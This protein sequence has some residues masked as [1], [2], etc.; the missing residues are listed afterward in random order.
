M[1][2]ITGPKCPIIICDN[3]EILI[4]SYLLLSREV[5]TI[6]TEEITL[7]AV[8]IMAVTLVVIIVIAI[9]N[10]MWKRHARQE[11]QRRA[12]EEQ[13]RDDDSHRL[14]KWN[15]EVYKRWLN[16]FVVRTDD[17][18]EDGVSEFHV[19]DPPDE[20]SPAEGLVLTDI[21]EFEDAKE[22]LDGWR[23]NVSDL[24]AGAEAL[25]DKTD[26]A[27]RQHRAAVS[28]V[29]GQ[30][31][32]TFF[33][34]FTAQNSRHPP[35]ANHYNLNVTIETV[36]QRSYSWTYEVKEPTFD[37][38][39]DQ[40]E[41][42]DGMVVR[43]LRNASVHVAGDSENVPDMD[44]YEKVLIRCSK[45]HDASDAARTYIDCRGKRKEALKKFKNAL[46]KVTVDID[47]R[48]V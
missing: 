48:Y 5:T 35:S 20:K 25:L 8:W 26:V 24:W 40:V 15:N 44:L 11:D 29:T 2:R 17:G 28:K 13:Q 21:P 18:T 16:V 34:S 31:M 43:V 39:V 41:L 4:R 12:Q 30:E 45:D 27:R 1:G 33:Q 6:T 19:P 23:P 36:R 42:G 47:S 37:I 9:I 32:A 14:N 22:H 38:R 3:R 46:R 7:L 10:Q